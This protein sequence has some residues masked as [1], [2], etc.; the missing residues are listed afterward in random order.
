LLVLVRSI[1]ISYKQLKL[2]KLDPVSTLVYQ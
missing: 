2:G 1:N